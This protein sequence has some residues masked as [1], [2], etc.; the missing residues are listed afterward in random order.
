MQL[1]DYFEALNKD[2]RY[3]L[4]PIG[5]AMPNLHIAQKISN[6]RFKIAGGE[7]GMQVSW[8]VTG[9][10]QD[11]YAKAHPIIP[12]VEKTGK[13]RGKYLH[14]KEYGVSETLGIDYEEQQKIE[15][16]QTKIKAMEEKMRMEQEKISPPRNQ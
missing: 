13:E 5:A 3:Q 6:N 16:E 7:P 1:P 4:T 8:Q 9:I 14:P 2:Y 15:A 12:E 11:P 10:R